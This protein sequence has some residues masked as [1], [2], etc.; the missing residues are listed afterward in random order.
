MA[1]AKRLNT[2]AQGRSELVEERTL[3]IQTINNVTPKALH[4][5]NRPSAMQNKDPGRRR[6]SKTVRKRQTNRQRAE[7]S[8]QPIVP[9]PPASVVPEVY[10]V[11][12]ECRHEAEQRAVFERMCG[13][14]FRCR[15][16]VM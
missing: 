15:V 5:M 12:I 14:G 10:E 8:A 4:T 1:T 16:V 11:V 13:E 3:G 6:R 2:K 9:A 7:S